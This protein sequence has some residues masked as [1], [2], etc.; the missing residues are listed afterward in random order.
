MHVYQPNIMYDTD[1]P[2]YARLQATGKEITTKVRPKAVVIFSAHWQAD[3]D[4]VEVNTAEK[5]D[6]IYEFVLT[7]RTKQ[8]CCGLSG[9]TSSRGALWKLSWVP[10]ALLSGAV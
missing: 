8:I 1:H 2:A 9:L 10:T 3:P 7:S 5:T 4:V 6:L